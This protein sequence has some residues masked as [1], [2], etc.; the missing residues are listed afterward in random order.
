MTR[1]RTRT[2]A[3]QIAGLATASLALAPVLSAPSS[4]A[5]AA[6]TPA[7]TSTVEQP[8]LKRIDGRYLVTLEGTATP[9]GF[10]TEGTRTAVQTLVASAGGRIVTDLSQQIGVV[11]VEGATANLADL[12]EASTLVDSVGSDFAVKM[13]A[14]APEP[15]ADPLEGQQW[16]MQQIRTEQAHAKQAG[17]PAVDVGVL[18]SGIDGRHPDFMKNGV[19]NVDC[20][21]GRDSLAALPPGVAVG[22]PDV[23]SDNQFHGTHVAGTIGARANGLGIV[24]V[25][26]N[27]TLVPVKVCDS[28]GYCY[29]SPVVDGITYAGDQ[30]LDVINMSFFVDDN[31]FQESTEFKC[32]SDPVQRTFRQAVERAIS[33]ARSRGVTP[34][35]AL[36]NSDQD[37]AHP[38]G[39]DG[40]PISN[41]C[42]VVPAETQGV[43][44]TASLGRR[45]EKAGYSNYG[46]GMTDVAAPGGNGQTG[47]C[48]TTI[49]STFPGGGYICIQGTSMASPHA[50][51]VAAL[52]VSQFGR[53]GADGDVKLPPQTV[54]NYLQQTAVD[55][56]LPGYDECFGNGRIDAFRAVTKTTGLARDE[57]A[58]P[59]PEYAE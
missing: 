19:S 27:V 13:F 45:S 18:D 20:S 50:A 17:V 35:A 55:I 22:T 41:E 6:V 40:Q 42:E 12:L 37:L 4:A 38:V 58:P 7:A 33:Y 29:A 3:A 28:S 56:G 47:N 48:S 54:E 53:V 57:S 59:C 10:A 36:G 52:I 8:A 49:L 21:R 16:D 31:E 15:S 25:A 24:G 2:R 23:C 51:G 43:V 32:A 9:D 34:V 30:Q 11:V 46:T 26:P 44:G 39:E 1:T 14:D 5:P